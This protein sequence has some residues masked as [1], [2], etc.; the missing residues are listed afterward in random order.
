MMPRRTFLGWCAGVLSFVGLAK[1]NTAPLSQRP[2]DV[3]EL[4]MYRYLNNGILKRSVDFACLQLVDRL[5]DRGSADYL[6]LTWLFRD[7]IIY[8]NAFLVPGP[9]AYD[10]RRVSPHDI[11]LTYDA[12]TDQLG[13][14]VLKDGKLFKFERCDHFRMRESIA[15]VK[16]VGFDMPTHWWED[17]TAEHMITA[18]DAN[19]FTKVE[20]WYRAMGNETLA[21][22]VFLPKACGVAIHEP[23]LIAGRAL[24]KSTSLLPFSTHPLPCTSQ[25]HGEME[26]VRIAVRKSGGL[27]RCTI[28][29]W[30]FPERLFDEVFTRRWYEV[31]ITSKGGLA[32]WTLQGVKTIKIGRVTKLNDPIHNN[33]GTVFYDVEFEFE[34]LAT[35]GTDAGPRLG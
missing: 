1:A 34:Q 9:N 10:F 22:N 11:K 3:F 25:A 5:T 2:S 15:G 33:V 13:Y 35:G 31:R 7:I 21:P 17:V 12:Y 28:K 20:A 14:H 16:N 8:S 26:E 18:V 32:D 24:Q 23:V 29:Q 4:A 6:R 19:V 30:A 27:H